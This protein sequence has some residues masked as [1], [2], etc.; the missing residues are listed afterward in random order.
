MYFTVAREPRIPPIV[1]EKP[2]E[3]STEEKTK[4][5]PEASLINVEGK[6][7]VDEFA[8][9]MSEFQGFSTSV[10]KPEQLK[11][12]PEVVGIKSEVFTDAEAA[13]KLQESTPNEAVSRRG[14]ISSEQEKKLQGVSGHVEI[15]GSEEASSTAVKQEDNF[16][17]GVKCTDEFIKLADAQ[18]ISEKAVMK[19]KSGAVGKDTSAA[20][21][22]Q[23][24]EPE[25]G[26]AVAA[27]TSQELGFS[28]PEYLVVTHCGDVPQESFT[29]SGSFSIFDE[30][31][32][33]GLATSPSNKG[34]VPVKKL[35]SLKPKLP[36][37]LLLVSAGEGHVDMRTTRK[38]EN[39]LEPRLLVWQMN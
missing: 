11:P 14:I 8:R 37:P 18:V 16:P 31:R 38:G 28:S 36:F 25:E 1:E 34:D 27:E 7:K 9:L 30:T 6:I 19:P 13:E 17:A 10:S 21:I 29:K 4:D 24:D 12:Q 32:S 26:I 2:S 15:E 22:P 23:Y 20:A 35:Q 33:E 5:V 3:Q 39:G